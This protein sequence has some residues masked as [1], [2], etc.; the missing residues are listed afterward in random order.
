M[1]P[2]RYWAEAHLERQSD[3]GL[4]RRSRLAERR[5]DPRLPHRQAKATV[6]WSMAAQPVSVPKTLPL[7]ARQG[8]RQLQPW[9]PRLPQLP[10]W[11]LL[12]LPPWAP[13]RALLLL[14]WQVP[15][16]LLAL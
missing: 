7:L 8:A 1:A 14:P 11:A 13:L 15:L 3:W 16:R 4:A 12:Q 10:P 2:L 6:E 5:L 9:G